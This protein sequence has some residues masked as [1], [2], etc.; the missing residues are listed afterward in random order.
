MVSNKWI[1]TW[2]VLGLLV[3]AAGTRAEDKGKRA[4][5]ELG[6]VV[7]VPFIDLSGERQ[8]EK[9][10]YRVTALGEVEERFQK[11]EIAFA[12]R[13]ETEAALREVAI[14]PKDEEDRTKPKFAAL[15][16]RLKARYVVTG[17]LHDAK[18]GISQRGAFGA[19][20][21]AGQAKVQFRVFDATTGQY[22]DE[23][24]LTA[25]ST[26][27]ASGL[28]SSVFTRSNKLR[29]KAIRDATQKAMAAFLKPYP[30]VHDKLPDEK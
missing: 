20:T 12:T 14:N 18:S 26:A 2:A 13:E 29:V 21:K 8:E 28:T 27:R 9:D 4:P 17:I 22:R 16:E 7:I 15:A 25:T 10:E 3:V 23:L 5:S 11:Y 19:A 30:K 1:R 6:K 24:E